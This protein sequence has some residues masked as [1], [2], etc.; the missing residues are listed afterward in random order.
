MPVKTSPALRLMLPLLLMLAS[1]C[2]QLSPP[3]AAVVPPPRV[4]PLPSEARQPTQPKECLPTCSAALTKLRT[5]LLHT[6][7]QPGSPARPASAPT[8]P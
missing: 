2:A 1:G 7:T 6:L 5:E 3:P 4:P 8:T